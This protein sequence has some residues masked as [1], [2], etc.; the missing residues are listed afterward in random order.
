MKH[1]KLFE[2]FNPMISSEEFVDEGDSDKYSNPGYLDPEDIG[3][4]GEM[5]VA[6]A[7][8]NGNP[9]VA[10]CTQEQALE[11]EKIFYNPNKYHSPPEDVFKIMPAEGMAY[12]TFG[13]DPDNGSSREI[14]A[15]PAGKQYKTSAYAEFV[16]SAYPI[17]SYGSNVNPTWRGKRGSSYWRTY[18]ST[19]KRGHVL[20]DSDVWNDYYCDSEYHYTE[21]ESIARYMNRHQIEP[22]E[23]KKRTC[24]TP[25]MSPRTSK[26]ANPLLLA[27]IKK[28]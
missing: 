24:R 10:L 8:H 21:V 3:E 19:L 4:P 23:R 22:V 28:Q 16:S 9:G 11:L 6:W 14:Q 17:K 26:A 2:D 25:K 15:L 13:P 5:I 7:D 12:V 20:Y 18:V 27:K 1:V